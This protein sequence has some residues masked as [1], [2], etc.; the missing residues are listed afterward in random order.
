MGC[1]GEAS[2]ALRMLEG[3][4]SVAINPDAYNATA[5][6]HLEDDHLPDPAKW[7][8]QFQ[9]LLGETDRLSRRG[10]DRRRHPYNRGRRTPP[11]SS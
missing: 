8:E 3:V 4:E 10:G 11:V 2:Q 6:V 1:W 7:R 9:K 5:S